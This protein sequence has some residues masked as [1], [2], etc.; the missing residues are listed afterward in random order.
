MVYFAM[1]VFVRSCFFRLFSYFVISYFRYWLIS[2][3]MYCYMS[4]VRSFFISLF[5]YCSASV[6]MRVVFCRRLF[7]FFGMS[8]ILYFVP[9]LCV[10]LWFDGVC[11][12]CCPSFARSYVRLL[13]VSLGRDCGIC[14]VLSF[15]LVLYLSMSGF[16]DLCM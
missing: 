13:C 8:F 10:S 14:F 4:L 5:H 2:L 9:A 7:P 12:Y 11:M 16:L 1:C 6:F 15:S 3:C